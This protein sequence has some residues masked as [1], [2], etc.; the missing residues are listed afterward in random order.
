MRERERALREGPGSTTPG[1]SPSITP[2][3]LIVAG[4]AS[5]D[6]HAA[7]LVAAIKE[8][9]PRARFVGIG[10]DRL[11]ARGVEIL[12]PARE[13]AVVGFVEV[14]R[15]LPRVL[16]AL[17]LLHRLLRQEPPDLCILVDF[18]DFNFL[19]M[20]L[21][22]WRGVPVM[23]YISP[24]VWAWRRYRVRALARHV[25]RL[26]VIFPFEADF[27]RQHGL[28]ADFVGHPLRDT[29][30][31]LPPRRELAQSLGLHPEAFT[32][33]LLPGSREGEI[34]RHLPTL[35]EAA[36]HL[37]RLIPETQF[38][39][40]LAS[41]APRELVEGMVAG[42]LGE[43]AKGRGP[44][45][46]PPPPLPQTHIGGGDGSLRGG[47]RSHC[48]PGPPFKTLSHGAYPALAAAHLAIA[49]SGTVT[50]EAALAGTPTII[51][52]RLSRLTYL[53]GRLLVR[54]RYIGMANLLAGE[55][56]FPELLQDE[57]QAERI[58]AEVVRLLREPARLES[59]RRGVTR[60]VASLGGPGAAARAA[61]VAGE[62]LS[63]A[64]KSS[65]G[66]S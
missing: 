1:P 54:V 16:R 36:G 30:P 47:P 24:Q 4:E 32:V 66:V 25:D 21:A 51:V 29:L 9:L 34:R 8:K 35:L 64:D 2:T 53:L 60:V 23:Y 28:A 45:P 62:I 22:T 37:H 14:A 3:I 15:H 56:I 46:S 59:L 12:L 31:S 17:K 13:L 39:L 63:R 48:S 19:V 11:A 10:G 38:L 33:A 58:V 5:G 49:A 26:A 52:Y 18:P 50:V 55:E 6:E 27:Y 43:G 65:G 40:P 61:E 57:F 7:G 20:R 42:F 44:L 41:T